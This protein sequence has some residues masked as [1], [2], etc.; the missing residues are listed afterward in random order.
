MSQYFTIDIVDNFIMGP[1]FGKADEQY[2]LPGR[3]LVQMPERASYSQTPSAEEI[4][5]ALCE[6][7]NRECSAMRVA[8]VTDI[9]EQSLIYA[10]KRS[11]A[12]AYVIGDDPADYPYLSLEANKC[13]VS[14]ADKVQEV[15][16][17]SDPWLAIIR[18]EL[19]SSRVAVRK[20]I[21]AASNIYEAAAISVVDWQ[22]IVSNALSENEGE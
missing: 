9:A 10:E 17:K 20:Q 7:V 21:R 18:P 6:K 14:L 3:V 16:A 13:G 12:E 2:P 4:K 8:F 11:E 5:E 22:A 15:K 19:E 1:N